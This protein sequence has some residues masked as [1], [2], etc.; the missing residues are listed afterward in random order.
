MGEE[1]NKKDT[2]DV[3]L[4]YD[5]LVKS[6]KQV[7]DKHGIKY[8][9]FL[10]QSS[11]KSAVVHKEILDILAKFIN[12]FGDRMTLL[13]KNREDLFAVYDKYAD[14]G[15]A[16]EEIDEYQLKHIIY[17]YL[18]LF[19]NHFYTIDN[20][21]V[22]LTN[23]EEFKL[24]SMEDKPDYDKNLE[25]ITS[26]ISKKMYPSNPEQ[27]E[28]LI[29]PNGT[30]YFTPDDHR[31]LA[32]W[33]NVNGVDLDKAI[34]VESSKRLGEFNFTSLFNYKF[35]KNSDENEL[36]KITS[37]QAEMLGLVYSSLTSGW[38]YMKPFVE[39]L[40]M[41]TGFGFG[42]KEKFDPQGL[43]AEN[44]RKLSTYLGDF[45]TTSER[46]EY[47]R[48]MNLSNDAHNPLR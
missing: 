16:L 39:N 25:Y 17:A 41:T 23:N 2:K 11:D 10:R 1:Q 9:A 43:S 37:P 7:L 32:F 31:T 20:G 28:I 24:P 19:Y 40:R 47:I 26:K 38:L 29:L 45:F 36:I 8:E 6:V 35:S 44:L 21:K 12:T 18:G 3:E 13:I 30:T 33:L 14:S 42:K 34:R 27:L 22:N 4:M 46:T 5:L 48:E 15:K